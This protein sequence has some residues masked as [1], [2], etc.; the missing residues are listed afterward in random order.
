MN[1]GYEVAKKL[2]ISLGL[3]LKDK[4]YNKTSE[5][6]VDW[7]CH[8]TNCLKDGNKKEID[9][10]LDVHFP[11][12]SNLQ[13]YY[14]GMILQSPLRVYSLCSDHLLPVIYSVSIAY[15]PSE[16][17]QIGFSKLTRAIRL[18][19]QR[20]MN[21]ED[22]T[23]FIVEKLKEKLQPEGLGVLVKGVH[24]CTS[25]HGVVVDTNNI[26]SAVRGT[27]KDNLSTKEE[28]IKI[29]LTYDRN[30]I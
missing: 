28:F 25:M 21:Q 23:Q 6:F 10:V 2:L 15:I 14:K 1:N 18:M 3:D 19:A 26:T 12:H 9:D 11:K 24:M 22:F 20:P 8:F 17:R 16:N 7:L 13:S 27:F 29:A 4:N 5:H 30:R